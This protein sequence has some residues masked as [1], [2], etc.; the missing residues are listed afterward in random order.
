MMVRS[1]LA[2]VL[3]LAPSA[4]A[5]QTPLSGQARLEV[6]GVAPGACVVIGPATATATNASYVPD[7]PSAGELRITQMVTG[8]DSVSRGATAELALN[9]VCNS[10][11][12]LVL[13][14]EHGGLVLNGRAGAAHSGPY[15]SILPYRMRATWL[16][17][18]QS[19][20][21]DGAGPLVMRSNRGGS[22]QLSLGVVVP[23]GVRLVA[24]D[25]RDSVILEFRVAD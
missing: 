22:G 7:G 9:V 5:A 18:D 15:A 25:Y 14:S 21:S 23:A 10:P 1:A 6:V 19:S 24:G 16:G 11:H 2:A 13:R 3:L 20:A 4:L 17:E 8:P 12:H